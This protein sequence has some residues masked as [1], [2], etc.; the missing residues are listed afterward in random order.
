MDKLESGVCDHPVLLHGHMEPRFSFPL[1]S[2][3]RYQLQK[4]KR[5][6]WYVFAR[7]LETVSMQ[8]PAFLSQWDRVGP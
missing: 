1:S 5:Y 4:E 2:I 6:C 3:N 7:S 8:A